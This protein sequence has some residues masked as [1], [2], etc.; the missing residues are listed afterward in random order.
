[1]ILYYN[2]ISKTPRFRSASQNLIYTKYLVFII[3]VV[4]IIYILQYVA[5][6]VFSEPHIYNVYQIILQ[7][8]YER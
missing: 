7:I 1:M 6:V 2:I 8:K 4:D 3:L 5:L